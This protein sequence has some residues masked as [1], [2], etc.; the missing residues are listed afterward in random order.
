MTIY[1]KTA[2]LSYT[3]PTAVVINPVTGRPEFG[4][5]T[6]LPESVDVSIHE[7]GQ[8][9]IEYEGRDILGLRCH[10]RLIPIGTQPPDWLRP[11]YELDIVWENVS[12][13]INGFRRTGKFYILNEAPTRFQL[14]AIFGLHIQGI[15]SARSTAQ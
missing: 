2:T 11:G 14:N 9:N 3:K 13:G 10:G 8:D 15:Y 12:G 1:V 4:V 6:N 7:T 5:N